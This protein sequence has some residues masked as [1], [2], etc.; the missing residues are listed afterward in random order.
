MGHPWP[1]FRFFVFSNTH[2]NSTTNIREKMLCSSNIW[3]WYS[4]PRPSEHESL[5]ITTHLIKLSSKSELYS[6]YLLQ[7]L[8]TC[9]PSCTKIFQF[10]TIQSE[11]LQME[12]GFKEAFVETLLVNWNFQAT[13]GF[14]L[15]WLD[16]EIFQGKHLNEICLHRTYRTCHNKLGHGAQ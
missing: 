16:R 10:L 4:N 3:R 2:Y 6:F 11:W 9:P 1:L 14:K 5:P 12:K 13:K 15:N 7:S 8:H